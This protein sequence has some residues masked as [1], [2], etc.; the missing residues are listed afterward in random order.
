[1]EKRNSQNTKQDTGTLKRKNPFYI[2]TVG[3]TMRSW[4][5]NIVF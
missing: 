2:Q 4:L 3:G 1:M 5:R